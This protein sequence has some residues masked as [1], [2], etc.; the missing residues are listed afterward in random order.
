MLAAAA[1]LSFAA[2][3]VCAAPFANQAL[4]PAGS[5][6]DICASAAERAAAIGLIGGEDL[7][8]CNLAVRLA[9]YD[10]NRAAALTN[11]AALLF[12]AGN[13]NAVIADSTAALALDNGMAEALVNRGAA[14]LQEHRAA[15]AMAD[16]SQALAL[17]P[18]HPER[19]YLD[20]AMA[21]EDLGDFNGA[22]ADYRQAAAL[23]P[24][25]DLPRR[26]LLR[27]NVTPATPI[28]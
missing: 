5:A 15:A 12:V 21:R 1:G 28:S 16:F 10:P 13:Y 8:S 27:F 7:A 9:Y 23:N 18:D 6:A 20:R 4:R 22:Y 17:A 25:W 3:S 2:T 19:V 24:A 26:E 11:R 14:L